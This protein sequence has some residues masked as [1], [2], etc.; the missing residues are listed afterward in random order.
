MIHTAP[1]STLAAVTPDYRNG[2]H[3]NGGIA[4]EPASP[5]VQI[6][7]T[8]LKQGEIDHVRAIRE[9]EAGLPG[10]AAAL[11]P[12][13]RHPL[14]A[15]RLAASGVLARRH[16]E[17]APLQFTL[18]GGFSV[19][20]GSWRADDAAWGTTRRTKSRAAAA[21]APRPRP[22]RGRD[23]RSVLAGPPRRQ[24]PPQSSRRDLPR[25]PRR[26]GRTVLPAIGVI[27]MLILGLALPAYGVGDVPG[28]DGQDGVGRV[29][30]QPV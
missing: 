4:S 30:W 10:G 8:A 17:P 5:L 23:H 24:R 7:W 6:V 16:R 19:T 9:I 2:A 11:V 21:V 12:F 20:R 26:T 29:C 3:G 15:V 18:L 22:R 28:V 1:T 25:P 27:G 14:P 13:T